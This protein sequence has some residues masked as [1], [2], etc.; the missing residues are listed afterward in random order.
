MLFPRQST[1]SRILAA[2]LLLGMVAVLPGVPAANAGTFTI[3]Q[4]A[5]Y[6]TASA[7]TAYTY[8]ST[9]PTVMPTTCTPGAA[10]N[11]FLFLGEEQS[12]DSGCTAATPILHHWQTYLYYPDTVTPVQLQVC[13]VSNTPVAIKITG[14]GGVQGVIN[15][16]GTHAAKTSYATLTAGSTTKSKGTSNSASTWNGQAIIAPIQQS[17]AR[18]S[19]TYDYGYSID[20]WSYAAAADSFVG[21]YFDNATCN[22]NS[23]DNIPYAVE[24]SFTNV[25]PLSYGSETASVA[26]GFTSGP[27]TTTTPASSIASTTATINGT[28]TPNGLAI[29]AANFVWGTDPTLATGTTSTST[30]TTS[31]ANSTPSASL[32][33]LT[34]STT[35]YYELNATNSTSS[36]TSNISSFTTTAGAGTPPT[37]ASASITGTTTVGQTLTAV[38][39][40]VT[41]TTPITETY[42]WMSSST[43]GGSYSNIGGATGSTYVLQAGDA[44]MYIKVTITEAN[45][46]T[47]NASATSS[48]SAQIAAAGTPPT[49]ASASITGT[50]TVGQ[51]LTA[52]SHTVTG[53]TPITEYYQWSS[54]ST[55]GGS[56]TNIFHA[57]SSTYVLQA[58]DATKYIKVTITEANTF[59][60]DASAT[61]SPTTAI[62]PIAEPSP[63]AT[64]TPTP[65]PPPNQLSSISSCGVASGPTTGGNVYVISGS[66][67]S[68][69]SHVMLNS[70]WISGWSQTPTTLSITM[71]AHS[72]GGVSITIYNGQA[73]VLRDCAYA[74]VVGTPTPSATPTE[75]PKPTPSAT[76]T[77]TPKPTPTETPKPTPSATPTPTPTSNQATPVTPKPTAP[78]SVSVYFDTAQSTLTPAATATLDKLVQGILTH[79][80]TSVL[81]TGYTDAQGVATGYNNQALSQARAHQ[82]AAYLQ[83][84]LG[85]SNVTIKVAA[86]SHLNPVASNATSA[87]Q[88]LNRRVEITA[89]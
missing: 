31:S 80:L 42:Q 12:Y 88:A 46:Y 20:V 45:S 48:P 76:P 57:T 1:L 23:D 26:P 63:S 78:V 33:G 7:S 4:P 81:V 44:T 73:P 69:I 18:S 27:A 5:N 64:P 16:W 83:S 82:V 28:I 60:P 41:G 34:A 32:T 39:N 56:Y 29:T 59:T 24:N 71:P 65:P 61:S 77:E 25:P 38:S 13:E 87:G 47:P 52:V 89:H 62:N 35:Y 9:P 72:A 51:T 21:V 75:T 54:S 68:P 66:F 36:S 8:S 67:V 11:K 84:K 14:L 19:S 43:S 85:S 55:S 17:V 6:I 50:T 58:G 22:Q 15:D 10:T 37:I 3:A 49:I 53:T 79:E 30:F 40:T 70:Q 2:T 86:K 74:Y